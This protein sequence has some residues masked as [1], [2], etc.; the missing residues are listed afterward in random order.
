M[1]KGINGEKGR[2]GNLV[3]LEKKP[4]R[5]LILNFEFFALLL[6]IGVG[7]PSRERCRCRA[8]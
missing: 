3:N 5:G 6:S 7:L 1:F 2:K 8:E 4:C